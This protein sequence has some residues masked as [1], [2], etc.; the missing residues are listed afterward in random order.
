MSGRRHRSLGRFLER[1]EREGG[2]RGETGVGFRR[3]YHETR[4]LAASSPT[5]SRQRGGPEA[6]AHRRHQ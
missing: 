3:G 1:D 2:G 6:R 4:G 5:P